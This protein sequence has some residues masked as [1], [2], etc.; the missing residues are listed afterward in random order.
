LRP[1]WSTKRV[2]G[3]PELY[4]RNPVS[5]KTKKQKTN[6]QK[7]QKDNNNKKRGLNS[8]L[9]SLWPPIRCDVESHS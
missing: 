8:V 6:K 2:P 4:R 7:T 9:M 1:A 5:K 3:E